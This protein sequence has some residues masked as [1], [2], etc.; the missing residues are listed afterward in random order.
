MRL[1]TMQIKTTAVGVLALPALGLGLA[2][3]PRARASH[4]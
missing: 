4:T 1:E 3:D 2:G